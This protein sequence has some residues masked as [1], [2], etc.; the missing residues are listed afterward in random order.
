MNLRKSYE[1]IR[2][3]KS[4]RKKMR[5]SEKKS[6]QSVRKELRNRNLFTSDKY[7]DFTE[8]LRKFVRRF[9]N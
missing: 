6:Y 8:I 9:V 4:L 2:H 7:E 3:T 1:V 5:F